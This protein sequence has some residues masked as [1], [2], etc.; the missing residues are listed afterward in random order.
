MLNASTPAAVMVMGNP[1]THAA[2][3]QGTVRTPTNHSMSAKSPSSKS[4]GYGD[5][6]RANGDPVRQRHTED[7][8]ERKNM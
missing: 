1:R 5:F 2:L 4:A 8:R 3:S 7:R 6:D